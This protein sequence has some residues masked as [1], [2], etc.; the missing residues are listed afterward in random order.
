MSPPK[1]DY[2]VLGARIDVDEAIYVLLDD[3]KDEP[4]YY[5]LPYSQ[6]AANQ[7]QAA[8]DGAADGEGGVSMTMDG[9][10]SP[11]FAEETPPPD[12]EKRA[13][14]AILN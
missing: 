1:G 10:G 3:G 11:G 7:L 2:A 5:R 12:P 14:R 4:R 6:A 8:L 9:D 13:E